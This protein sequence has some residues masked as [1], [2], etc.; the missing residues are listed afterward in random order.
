MV[1]AEMTRLAAVITTITL[2][3]EQVTIAYSAMMEVTALMEVQDAITSTAAQ[4]M[5]GA[6]TGRDTCPVILRQD[7]ESLQ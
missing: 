2:M 5:T 7:G 4:T 6:S 1:T 3:A